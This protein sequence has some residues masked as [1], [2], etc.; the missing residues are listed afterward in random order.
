MIAGV[1]WSHHTPL[2]FLRVSFAGDALDNSHGNVGDVA[3]LYR[4]VNGGL[5]L[6]PGVGVVW[7]S[8]KQNDDYYGVS[9]YESLRSGLLRY[10]PGSSVTP[11][12]ELSANYRFEGA[13]SVRFSAL[14]SSV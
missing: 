13:G 9:R 3:W 11:Y 14:P 5:M 2:G 12:L 7:S 1:T 6:T 10:E 4:Y 8:R